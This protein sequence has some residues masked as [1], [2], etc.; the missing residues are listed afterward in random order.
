VPAT[1]DADFLAGVTRLSAASIAYWA[2]GP[3]P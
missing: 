2:E 3:L 1:L